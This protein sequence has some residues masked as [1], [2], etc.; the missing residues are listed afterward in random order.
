MCDYSLHSV[1]NRPAVIGEKLV[2]TEF[3]RYTRGFASASDPKTAVCLLP[4]TEVA[5]KER[6]TKASVFWWG[7][8]AVYAHNTAVFR[9]LN[10]G[11]NEH[12][13]ALEMP[14]GKRVLLTLLN[15]GQEA[16][17]IQMPVEP[18]K[19]E[20]MRTRLLTLTGYDEHLRPVTEEI[21]VV[22]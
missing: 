8:W 19:A 17:V 14:D 4:G 5:F 9:Q 13:D 6:I 16:T 2:V 7:S 10:V 1:R 12:H 20:P 22:S 3:N 21:E 11:P 15:K 18:T